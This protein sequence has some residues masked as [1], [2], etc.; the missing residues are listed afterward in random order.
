M[1]TEIQRLSK[2]G[3]KELDHLQAVFATLNDEYTAETQRLRTMSATP[4]RNVFEN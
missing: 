2:T 4:D 3:T 1:S